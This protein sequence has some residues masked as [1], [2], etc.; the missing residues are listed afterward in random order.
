M[1]RRNIMWTDEECKL[2]A[3]HIVEMET[4]ARKSKLAVTKASMVRSAMDA[5]LPVTRR[6]DPRFPN[7][8]W[9]T[10]EPFI[11]KER[12]RTEREL[13]VAQKITVSPTSTPAPMPA[14]PVDPA[15]SQLE[16]KLNDLVRQLC[17]GLAKAISWE[18]ADIVTNITKNMVIPVIAGEVRAA[19]AA[20]TQ[21]VSTEGL[22][23]AVSRALEQHEPLVVRATDPLPEDVESVA[24]APRDRLPRV[25]IIG[26]MHQ[27]E[28]D[29]ERQFKDCIEFTF[30]RTSN[31][32]AA[33]DF[34]LKLARKDVVILMTKFCS[35]WHDEQIKRSG[36]PVMRITG[37]VSMLKGWLQ[38]WFNGEIGLAGMPAHDHSQGEQA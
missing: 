28:E 31:T 11:V 21:P 25:A 33:N 37:G 22:E 1:A 8:L 2:L 12:R 34:Q 5:E 23:A 17:T 32:V 18:V 16:V 14:V 38:K 35:H 19:L 27:Q 29:V 24:I 4:T 10:L 7:P 13:K 20:M 6:R 15:P 9:A 26:L 3:K 36:V 30:I